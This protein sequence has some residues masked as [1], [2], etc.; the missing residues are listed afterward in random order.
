MAHE[1]DSI[2]LFVHPP[3]A[4]A[5]YVF[6]FLFAVLLFRQKARS[7]ALSL[8]G[9]S[10]WLLTLLGLVTGMLWAQIAWGTYW[11]WDPKE[12]MTLLLFLSV[13]GYLVAY[14]EQYTELTKWLAVLSS[15]LVLMT[16][17]SSF[18]FGG[19]HSFHI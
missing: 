14:Y 4:V 19:L 18:I 13:S 8:C 1:L 11:S 6:I 7:R 2:M 12:T 17:F 5:A 15:V 16:A 10:A 9:F 3:L